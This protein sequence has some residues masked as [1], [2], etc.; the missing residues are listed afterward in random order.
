MTEGTLLGRVQERVRGIGVGDLRFA[1]LALGLCGTTLL[2]A[3][4]LFVGRIAPTASAAPL[5]WTHHLPHARAVGVTLQVVGMVLLTVAW[6]QLRHRVRGASDG[7]HRT[8]VAA[9][10]WF[11]P[12]AL[13][14]PMFSNDVW[15]YVADGMVMARHA[16]PYQVTP[17]A[18]SGPIVHAV[19]A[20]WLYTP[21]PYGPLP[22]WWGGVVAGGT[23]SPW[24]QLYAFRLLAVASLVLL[25][26]AVGQIARM[27]GVDPGTATWIAVASPFTVAN[28]LVSAHLDLPVA[29]LSAAALALALRKNVLVAAVLVGLAASIKFPALVVA[30]PVALAGAREGV[31]SLSARLARLAVITLIAAGVVWLLGVWSDLG[32]GWVH[33]MSAP[34]SSRTPL[35]PATDLLR[36]TGRLSGSSVMWLGR[37]LGPAALLALGAWMLCSS[38]SWTPSRLVGCA[39]LV[40]CL[41]VVLSPVV[42]QWYFFWCLPFLVCLGL[43]PRWNRAVVALTVV[44]GL[45]T[46]DDL[47]LHLPF[48]GTFLWTALLVPLAA[49]LPV[50]DMQALVPRVRDLVPT[51]RRQRAIQRVGWEEPPP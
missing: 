46:V 4:S 10:V 1:E 32:L 34:L 2:A 39:A 48:A 28:G 15:S 20:R 40:T 43:R 49:V 23:S 31:S 14:P 3:A 35:A 5:V 8:V 13:T 24:L 29:A 21:S 30:L 33:G 16:S 38:R 36:L 12:L 50:P 11:A 27:V 19:S 18:L 6:W 7:V 25:A 41:E 44:L 42:H 22:L 47:S 37:Y 51:R 9:L 17:A 26:V 45:L